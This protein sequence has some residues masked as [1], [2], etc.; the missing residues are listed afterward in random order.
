MRE[1][2]RRA[3]R[4]SVFTHALRAS[5][6]FRF[7]S[8]PPVR[9]PMRHGAKRSI[10]TNRRARSFARNKPASPLALDSAPRRVSFRARLSQ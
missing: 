10:P 6:N 5:S 8:N 7:A 4:R 3:A 2:S 1:R 9:P